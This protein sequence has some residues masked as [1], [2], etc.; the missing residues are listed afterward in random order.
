M[1]KR[2]TKTLVIDMLDCIEKIELYISGM[3]FDEFLVDS[4]TI[5]AVI[6][7]VQVIGEAASRI[8][9]EFRASHPDIE[10]NKIIRSRHIVTHEYDAIDYDIIWRIITF[11]LPQNKLVLETILKNL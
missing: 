4:K 3:K 5:D 11:H 7:N 10:W 9:S 2:P 6:R 8:P 1:S